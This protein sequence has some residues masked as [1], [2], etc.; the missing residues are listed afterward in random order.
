MRFLN[1][2]TKI[3][4]IIIAITIASINNVS[5]RHPL[6]EYL[7]FVAMTAFLKI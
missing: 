6:K 2:Y 7:R 3:P 4:I 5:S 1:T